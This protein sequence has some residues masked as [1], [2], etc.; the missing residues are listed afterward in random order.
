MHK[1]QIIS[2]LQICSFSLILRPTD[3]KP[4]AWLSHYISILKH[5][6]MRT[7]RWPHLFMPPLKNGVEC[8]T[9]AND[10]K[11]KSRNN[12][13]GRSATSELRDEEWKSGLKG[14]FDTPT[15]PGPL[16]VHSRI[17]PIREQTKMHRTCPLILRLLTILTVVYDMTDHLG[18]WFE[19]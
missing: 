5:N 19:F 1:K 7:F 18:L 6:Q 14:T 17:A 9:Y 13:L 3:N 16:L 12:I 11:N 8:K 10:I 15:L 2:W 4:N